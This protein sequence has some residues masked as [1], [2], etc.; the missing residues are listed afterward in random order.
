MSAVIAALRRVAEDLTFIQG[1]VALIGGLAVSARAEPRF[2]RDM[3]FAVAVTGDLAAE[4]IIFSLQARGYR[5][6]MVVEQEKTGR[7]ATVRLIPPF[8]TRE[9]LFVD[10]LFASSGIE[11]EIVAR[12]EPLTIIPGLLLPVASVGHLLAMKLLSHDAAR[13]PRDGE[14]LL[15]LLAVARA[16]DLEECRAALAL[17][18]A[19]GSARGKDLPAELA[20]FLALR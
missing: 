1:Q 15:A 12:A 4:R 20:R 11:P 2:T 6:G 5:V 8:A 16:T 7:M 9:E 3:D 14:D 18:E 19:R 17:I 10:L 13:R